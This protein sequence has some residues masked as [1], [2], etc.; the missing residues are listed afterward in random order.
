MRKLIAGLM[1]MAGLVIGFTNEVKACDDDICAKEFALEILDQ[2]MTQ[3]YCLENH[4]ACIECEGYFCA[5]LTCWCGK[6]VSEASY[7]TYDELMIFGEMIYEIYLEEYCTNLCEE[8]DTYYYKECMC[9]SCYDDC[10]DCLEYDYEIFVDD[11]YDM[12]MDEYEEV[13]QGIIDSR[14]NPVVEVV[15]CEF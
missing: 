4:T 12:I 7:M 8:C 11:Y 15:I 9:D 5:N 10:I 1:I 13:L 6:E 3:D 14:E 2:H